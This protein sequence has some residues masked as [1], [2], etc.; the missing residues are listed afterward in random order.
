MWAYHHKERWLDLDPHEEPTDAGR[1][2]DAGGFV[3]A[4]P[5]ETILRYI[6]VG[7]LRE[8]WE[9]LSTILAEYQM[10]PTDL[11]WGWL[12][13]GETYIS[14]KKLASPSNYTG[15]I[16]RELKRVDLDSRYQAIDVALANGRPALRCAVSWRS[17]KWNIA[18]DD[19]LLGLR[20][21]E[22]LSTDEIT[23]WAPAY[24][25]QE[26]DT[27]TGAWIEIAQA[28][29]ILDQVA[30]DRA[31]AHAH[32]TYSPLGYQIVV[33]GF[34]AFLHQPGMNPKVHFPQEPGM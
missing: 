19:Y 28:I 24:L 22:A 26:A 27:T 11:S 5:F 12:H 34:A 25:L 23:D 4:D 3:L 29:H 21:V 30:L 32:A 8:A 31:I 14:D 33:C 9:R 16:S 15:W 20:L 2:L 7:Y 10:R 1:R 18:P 13:S 17:L 6:S